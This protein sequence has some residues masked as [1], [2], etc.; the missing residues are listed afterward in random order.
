MKPMYSI[1]RLEGNL[2][3]ELLP[4]SITESLTVEPGLNPKQP[5]S[6]N[7]YHWHYQDEMQNQLVQGGEKKSIFRQKFFSSTTW[8]ILS[9]F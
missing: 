8:L 5:N 7:V 2:V 1:L 6:H 4:T 3:L 9:D